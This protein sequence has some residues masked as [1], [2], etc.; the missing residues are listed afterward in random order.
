VVLDNFEHVLEAGPRLAEL[1]TA[2][3]FITLV[4]TSRAALHLR[5]E[6]VLLVP[7][8]ALP[9]PRQNPSPAAL[10]RTPAIALFVDRARGVAPAFALAAEN[11]PAVAE[12][13]ARLDGLPLAIELAARQV[14]SQPPAA[15]LQRLTRAIS[16]RAADA[17]PGGGPGRALGRGPR[18]LPDRQRTLD[19]AIAWSY[20]LL[21][22]EE[23]AAF[24]RLSVFEGGF[25]PEAAAAVCDGVASS[26]G[27]GTS[28]SESA[29]PLAPRPSP[30]GLLARLVDS[31]LLVRDDPSGQSQQRYRL[32]ETIRQFAADRLAEAGEAAQ[33]RSRHRDWCL[34][35]AET[36]D[37]ELR[38]GGGPEWL[39]RLDAE[40]ENLRGALAWS[41]ER[42][43][44]EAVARLIAARWWYWHLRGLINETHHLLARALAIDTAPPAVRAKL[45]NG[46][47]LF[48]YDRGEYDQAEALATEARALCQELG[49]VGG[50]AFAQS[51]LGFIAYFR[52]DYD[53][54]AVLLDKGL[55]LARAAHDPANVA[56]ALNNLGVLA[57]ARGELEEVR[58]LFEESLAL[59]RQLRSD[60]AS[61]LALL[62]L[63]HAA[64]E[65]GDQQRATALLEES[66]ALARR[67]G[68]ARAAGPALYLQGQVARSL[69][70]HARA[71]AFFQE[72]LT[73]R[74]E[75]G[76]RRGIAECFE[77]LA[78]SADAGRKPTE[79]A[80][81]LGAADAQRAAI[82]APLPP[83]TGPARERLV[84]GLKRQL[85]ARY[86]ALHAEGAALPL[87]GA[88]RFA[89]GGETAEA[90]SRRRGTAGRRAAGGAD[91]RAG[92]PS[93]TLLAPREREVAA[94]VARGL[95]NREIAA[96]LVVAEGSAANYVKRILAKLRFRSRAQVAV[97]AAQH[98]LAELP[99]ADPA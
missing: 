77:G 99:V 51:S 29:S 22:S 7:P 24:R 75:Q 9:D 88:L 96:A 74:R 70:Q 79:A 85:G 52:G 50:A 13:C 68:Y 35:L 10:A 83:R 41:E 45:L 48:S 8:L 80:R 76:D 3:P 82:G 81:L 14:G 2:C 32:L 69:G 73:I 19:A 20:D 71:T 18:D 56:R 72:S 59:W 23:Q 91:D 89:L 58:A 16:D 28:G 46:A 54:A 65:Q 37:R 30:H 98:D 95:S 42:E 17:A 64:H 55:T 44:L 92:E 5:W 97:W 90:P 11:A 12:L 6:Q 43:E 1:L 67:T 86:D 26:E 78:A 25:T 31:S 84:A 15:I 36:G 39:P 61:A 93:P 21:T 62:F 53:R 49:D 66:V 63:G 87:D 4:V 94:L 33:A 38:S 27:R 47:T 57:L 40:H 34:H 60:G